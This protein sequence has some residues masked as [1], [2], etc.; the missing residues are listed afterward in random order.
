MGRRLDLGDFLGGL[1]S[2]LVTAATQDRGVI[3]ECWFIFIAKDLFKDWVKVG[4]TALKTVR[5]Q[6]HPR[7]FTVLTLLLSWQRREDIN[8]KSVYHTL[9]GSH[10]N[11]CE[12]PVT[13][14][15]PVV[16][17]TVCCAK[18]SRRSAASGQVLFYTERK[19][20]SLA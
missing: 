1:G 5:R 9:R 17:C 7:L 14:S 18:T 16:L 12:H 4:E 3:R 15:D 13:R 2:A 11:G 10:S 19:L 20:V 6:S 8:H